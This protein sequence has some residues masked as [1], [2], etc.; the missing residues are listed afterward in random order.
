MIDIDRILAVVHEHLE[1]SLLHLDKESLKFDFKYEWYDLTTLKGINEYLKDTTAMANTYG[2]DGFIVMGFDE[3]RKLF[4]DARFEDCGL[5]DTNELNK[6]IIKRVSH[7]FE[8]NSYDI[9]IDGHPLSVLHIPPAWEKP[10]FIRNYQTFTKTKKVKKEYHQKVFVRKNTGTF[11]ATKYD[12]DLMY[13]DRKNIEPDYR[14]FM[15]I[16]KV[17]FLPLEQ[18]ISIKFTVENAGKR[19]IAIVDYSLILGLSQHKECECPATKIW[20]ENGSYTPNHSSEI[21][22]ASN[23]KNFS[24][25]FAIPQK[26]TEDLMLAIKEPGVQKQLLLKLSNDKVILQDFKYSM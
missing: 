20:G 9:M 8:L 14:V 19:P 6:I 23:I 24:V 15:N 7:L 3:R 2:L 22:Q 17:S 16:F 5:K 25:E 1:Q 26:Q 10:F 11:S 4:K 21:V 12:I 13:Y 18:I